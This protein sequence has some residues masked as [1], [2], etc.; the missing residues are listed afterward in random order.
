MPRNIEQWSP[1]PAPFGSARGLDYVALDV[2]R[3]IAETFGA[4]VIIGRLP[5]DIAAEQPERKLA[6]EEHYGERADTAPGEPFAAFTISHD[7]LTLSGERADGN[8]HTSGYRGHYWANRIGPETVVFDLRSVPDHLIVTYAVRGPMLDVSLPDGTVSHGF[9]REE[10]A[11]N[12]IE[13]AVDAY[14]G[15]FG[16][17]EAMEI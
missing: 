11:G 17:L 8:S 3:R 5:A 13:Q 14:L 4:N 6:A 2:K 16:G 9:T 10:I 12:P 1:D 7:G 15:P